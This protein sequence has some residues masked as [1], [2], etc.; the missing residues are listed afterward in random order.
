MALS[1]S[2]DPPILLTVSANLLVFGSLPKSLMLLES[3]LGLPPVFISVL[4]SLVV[5]GSVIGCWLV[6]KS[7]LWPRLLLGSVLQTVQSAWE[8]AVG[9]EVSYS[10]R[11]SCQSSV[12]QQGMYL[13]CLIAVETREFLLCQLSKGWTLDTSPVSTHHGL[14]QD[15][16][17]GTPPSDIL[18]Q[19]RPDWVSESSHLWRWPGQRKLSWTRS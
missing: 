17:Y 19:K 12:G 2:T 14:R 3:F 13:D 10:S 7:I 16:P 4:G 1:E 6:F 8:S 9:T 5:L 18:N 11:T 15:G